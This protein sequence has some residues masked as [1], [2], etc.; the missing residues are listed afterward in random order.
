MERRRHDA[1][2]KG[3]AGK[4]RRHQHD[5]SVHQRKED[6]RKEKEERK[7]LHSDLLLL[8]RV[9][10]GLGGVVRALVLGLLS[11]DISLDDELEQAE[12][13]DDD[14]L[15][16]EQVDLGNAAR[17]DV[18]PASQELVT[19]ALHGKRRG[20]QED[21]EAVQELTRKQRKRKKET[22]KTSEH[23]VSYCSLSAVTGHCFS[24]PRVQPDSECRERAC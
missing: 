23:K 19:L 13:D 24:S 3:G 18:G 1:G 15:R 10:R 4:G 12:G 20:V 2:P 8:A 16:A 7:N 6:K 9:G 22:G 14:E 5:P 11:E 17:H 21:G